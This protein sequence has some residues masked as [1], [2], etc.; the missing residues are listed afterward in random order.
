MEELNLYAKSERART[1]E[2]PGG[3]DMEYG[4]I[5]LRGNRQGLRSGWDGGGELKV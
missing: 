2:A 4:G 1:E 3:S 5:A